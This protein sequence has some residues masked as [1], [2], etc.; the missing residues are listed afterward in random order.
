MEARPF[1]GIARGDDAI[2]LAAPRIDIAT[3]PFLRE[4]IECSPI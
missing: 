4:C 2:M 1:A 3:R